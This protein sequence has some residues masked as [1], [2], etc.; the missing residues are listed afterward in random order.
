MNTK[1]RDR[2]LAMALEYAKGGVTMSQLAAKYSVSRQR[3]HQILLA[4][5]AVEP[6][7]GRRMSQAKYAAKFAERR[8]A[9][10]LQTYGCSYDEFLRCTGGKGHRSGWARRWHMWKTNCAI[11]NRRFNIVDAE[12][13]AF[14][15]WITLWEE[16]GITD[17]NYRV[18]GAQMCRIDSRH[19]FERGNLRVVLPADRSVR[20]GG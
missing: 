7:D 1:K 15:E 14:P 2:N 4:T 18:S 17:K 8:D 3:V 19:W 9:R 6:T 5:G 20:R 10:C 13:P 16:A 12:L 11:A